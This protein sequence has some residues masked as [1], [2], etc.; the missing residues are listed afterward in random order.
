MKT[1]IVSNMTQDE[2]FK[3]R[4]AEKVV[5]TT[6]SIIGYT[7]GKEVFALRGISDFSF[8]SLDEGEVFDVS[9]PTVADLQA[10]IFA[11]TTALVTGGAI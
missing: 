5:K 2:N 1:L 11:L 3:P 8:F 6:D 10:Q 9:E 7:D 4:C